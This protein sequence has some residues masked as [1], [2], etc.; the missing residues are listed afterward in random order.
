MTKRL[1]LMGLVAASSIAL[2]ACQRN[3]H[4]ADDAAG[5]ASGGSAAKSTAA[6][7]ANPVESAM[8]A[9]PASISAAAA[10]V[11]PQA[12]GTMKTLRAGTNGWTCMPDIAGTP[13]P[14]PMCL[15]ANAL[16]WAE[17]LMSGKTP[18][19]GIGLAYMLAGGVDASNIDPAAKTPAAGKDWVRTGPHI[20][21]LNAPNLNAGYKGGEKPD[22]KAPS[23]MFGGTPYAHLMVPVS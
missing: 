6:A 23:V 11:A 4:D 12:D 9:A 8:S 13:G 22:T 3:D 20:M 10:I 14:D 21:I 1:V 2:V 17:A 18:P 16:K 7:P 15:D 5:G 19:Q